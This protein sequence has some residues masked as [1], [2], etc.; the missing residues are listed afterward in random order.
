M[1]PPRL[2]FLSTTLGV[3]GALVA[4]LNFNSLT[5]LGEKARTITV[6]SAFYDVPFLDRLAAGVSPTH[7]KKVEV[8]VYL[9]GFAGSRLKEDLERLRKWRSAA[10]RVFR[11]VDIFLVS[12]S[13]L[14][15]PK[16][17]VFER[18]SSTIALI[19]SANATTAAYTEN[20][21]VMLALEATALPSGLREYLALL[22]REAR[23]LDD[24]REPQVRSLIAFFRT[25]DIYFRP[26]PLPLFRFDLRLPDKLRKRLSRLTVNIPG[27]TAKASRTYNPFAAFG[28]TIEREAAEMADEEDSGTAR[29]ARI[30]IRPYAVQTCYGWWAPRAYQ[31]EIDAAVEKVSAKKRERLIRLRRAFLEGIENGQVVRQAKKSFRMLAKEAHK[32]RVPLGEVPEERLTRFEKFL[33]TCSGQLS[34]ERWFDRASRAYDRAAM[35][36]IWF[37]PVS[38]AEFEE[39]FFDYLQYVNS[40]RA[41]PKILK[42]LQNVAGVKKSDD[43]AEIKEKLVALLEE[44]GW[45]EHGWTKRG[46]P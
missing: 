33:E 35:P 39:S 12:Q 40:G 6:V 22:A 5:A 46:R 10:R 17:L 18:P 16:L 11:S 1:A 31:G 28:E 42:S 2:A 32:Q 4:P 3:E 21:E 23:G 37:D 26:N 9:H 24:V 7:R 45:P 8:S 34:N 15:H 43:A 36:E 27:F 25:G 38:R 30:S 20:E 19:G 14:F 41:T 13:G 29:R 44:A